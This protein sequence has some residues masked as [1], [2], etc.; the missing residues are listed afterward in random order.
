MKKT[1]LAAIALPLVCSIFFSCQSTDGAAKKADDTSSLVAQDVKGEDS[2]SQ[3]QNAGQDNAEKIDDKKEVAGLPDAAEEKI[4]ESEMNEFSSL[5]N[6]DSAENANAADTAQNDSSA[7]DSETETNVPTSSEGSGSLVEKIKNSNKEDTDLARITNQGNTIEGG[8]LIGP[9]SNKIPGSDKTAGNNPSTTK[10]AAPNKNAGN[11]ANNSSAANSSSAAANS[12]AANNSGNAETNEAIS[13]AAPQKE[14]EEEPAEEKPEPVPS[15]AMTI[16]NNQFVDVVYPGSGWIYLGEEGAD[17]HFIFQ[18]RKLGNGET[19]FTLR[20]KE[21]GVALLH[22]YKND[23]LTGNYIDDFIEISVTDKSATDATHVE[24]PSYAE[25]VPPKFDRTKAIQEKEVAQ[26]PKEDAPQ[27]EDKAPQSQGAKEQAPAKENEVAESHT[28]NSP[29]EKVQTVIQ[30]SGQEKDKGESRQKTSV[31]GTKAPE[32]QEETKESA[33]QEGFSGG[34]DKAKSLLER[35]QKAYDEKRYAEALDLVQQFF[36]TASE[37]FDAGLYLEGLILEAKSEVRN[38]KSAIGAYD[39]L[40]KN[41][42]QS[43]YWR[44][45]N[46]R[47]IYLKRFYIDIR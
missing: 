15:R 21:P 27:K 40:I 23:I 18:G 2:A 16:K 14:Q 30:T 13:L 22:F 42:P 31:A 11:S 28:E 9:S 47:S 17:D 44:K 26:A 25:V 41:W 38:I 5:L 32:A 6:E 33:L 19:T 4:S 37:D 43:N 34:T 1:L 46:E 36:D 3:D 39:T 45:A 20:S 29:S 10:N 8:P 35:A 24:A 7:N 12:S